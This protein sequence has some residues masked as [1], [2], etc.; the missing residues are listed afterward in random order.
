MKCL[1]CKHTV[2]PPVSLIRNFAKCKFSEN[3]VYWSLNYERECD[4][5][6]EMTEADR[7]A[8]RKVW[9]L[10]KNPIKKEKESEDENG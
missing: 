5:F 8:K 10:V 4:K 1:N 6:K 3:W 9:E 2:P 7:E